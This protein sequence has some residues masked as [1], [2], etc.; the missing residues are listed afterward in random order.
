MS[1]MPDLKRTA[2]VGVERAAATFE[3]SRKE[4]DMRVLEARSWGISLRTI[5]AAAGVSYET[6]RRICEQP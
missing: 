1:E 3:H 5:A 4:L 6:V 2:L